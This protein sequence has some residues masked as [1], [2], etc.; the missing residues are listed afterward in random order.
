MKTVAI[1]VSILLVLLFVVL[2]IWE[3]GIFKLHPSLM[4]VS[5]LGC[6]FQAIHIFSMDDTSCSP[7]LPRRKQILIHSFLQVGTIICSII[8]FTAIYTTKIQRNKPHFTS[9]H[10][11]IGLIVFIWSLLQAVAGLFLTIFQRY[12]R[13]LRLTYAQLRIYHA[14]S[15]VL[16]FTISCFVLI[17]GLA[18]NWFKNLNN[19]MMHHEIY[20][21][22]E[23]KA[24]KVTHKKFE[25][26]H[27]RIAYA[28]VRTL[29]FFFDTFTGYV[30]ESPKSKTN[31]EKQNHRPKK[32]MTE[33]EWLRRVI[34][35]E[36]IA[37]VPGMVA[38]MNRHMKSLRTMRRDHGWIH[39]LLSEA[40][41]E[42]MHLL[43]FLELRQPG[44]IFRAFVLL[45]Q[46]VFFNGF[47]LTYLLSPKI[48]HRFVGFLEEEAVITYTRCIEELDAG[49]LPIWSKTPAPQVAKNYWKLSDNAMMR[50]VLLAIRA[51]EATHRQVNHKL[52]DVGSN[53]PN[54]FLSRT[55]GEREPFD[56]TEQKEIDTAGKK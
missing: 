30:H 38:G 11:F 4:A 22:D 32:I 15:G 44:W 34:F 42:R 56:E 13:S 24:V 35:L 28:A 2:C 7:S 29:R 19:Y 6:M 12:I 46:G 8:A 17:L 52:A 36:S 14:T 16:L 3:V 21:T 37:G 53:A 48:C 31:N 23:L 50:D 39:T 10:G 43:T 54:P 33:K 9:W 26:W 51:D 1:V 47:F 20:S 5:Y 49:R 40:E 45:G 25:S 41:N 55:K 18:S 27:D